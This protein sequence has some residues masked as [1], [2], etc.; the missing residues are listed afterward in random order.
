VASI[1]V[2]GGGGTS[3]ILIIGAII[4]IVGLI[5]FIRKNPNF[6]KNLMGGG[7]KIGAAVEGI[8]RLSNRMMCRRG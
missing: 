1:N 6:L 5:L 7:A 3:Y 2:G 8:A 4:A